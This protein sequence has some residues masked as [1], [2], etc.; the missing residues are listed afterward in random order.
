MPTHVVAYL[1]GAFPSHPAGRLHFPVPAFLVARPP[2]GPGWLHEVKHDG[3]RIVARKQGERVTLWSRYGT[4]FT[5]RLPRI[6][7]AVGKLPAENALIDGEAV[8]FR[9]DGRSDFGALRT[10]AGGAE[11]LLVAF[12]L[13]GLDGE[14]LRQRPLEERRYRLA[15]LIAGADA[16]SFSEAI[17]AEGATVFA[18]AC[19]LGLEGIVSKRAG[20]RLPERGEP[21]LAQVQ[22]PRVCEDVTYAPRWRG[23]PVRPS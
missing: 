9:P 11:A 16:I 4:N 6:A 5:D 23:R 13:L 8:V 20:S 7:E 12:D 1:P 21:Q 17:E 22:E 10:K 19:K 18:H 14:D 3:Y 15:R 2:A